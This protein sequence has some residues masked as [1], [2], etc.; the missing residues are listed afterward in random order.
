MACIAAIC[1]ARATENPA[2]SPISQSLTTA[3]QN[4]R[5]SIQTKTL[6]FDDCVVGPEVIRTCLR[7]RPRDLGFQTR[8]IAE[9]VLEV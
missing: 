1:L 7:H 3:T 4:D 8:V 9:V 5:I 6:T 2:P